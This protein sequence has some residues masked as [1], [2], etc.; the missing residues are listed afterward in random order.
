MVKTETIPMREINLLRGMSYV[1]SILSYLQEEPL[2]QNCHSFVSVADA[3]KENFIAIER[4]VNRNRGLSQ[5]I[6]KMLTNIYIVLADLKMPENPS[7][8]KMADNCHMPSGIC[9]AK[10]ARGFYEKLEKSHDAP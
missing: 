9:L 10:S 7:R 6:S 1:F 3:A 4:A 2:C 5:G 8:Q